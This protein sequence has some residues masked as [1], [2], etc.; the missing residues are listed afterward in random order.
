MK[1]PSKTNDETGAEPFDRDEWESKHGPL[2]DDE[3]MDSFL[4]AIYESKHRTLPDYLRRT[5]K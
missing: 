2:F 4:E 5:K 1:K 3:T